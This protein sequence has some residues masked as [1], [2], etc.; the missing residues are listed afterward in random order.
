M[1]LPLV[2]PGLTWLVTSHCAAAYH[3]TAQCL[4]W[5]AAG[6]VV[7]SS[8]SAGSHLP[9]SVLH[10]AEKGHAQAD[11]VPVGEKMR[12]ISLNLLDDSE[13]WAL[14]NTKSKGRL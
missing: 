6:A 13:H 3:R 14:I 9:G 1:A 12:I 5:I 7:A 2:I 11:F 4:Q 10:N 8:G